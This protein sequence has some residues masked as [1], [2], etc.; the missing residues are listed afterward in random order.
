M[1]MQDEADWLMR[2]HDHVKLQQSAS[3][4]AAQLSVPAGTGLCCYHGEPCIRSEHCLLPLPADKFAVVPDMVKCFERL[5]AL[6]SPTT[7]V[8]AALCPC[9]LG[10]A[11]LPQG[12]QQGLVLQHALESS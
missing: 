1:Q 5:T 8:Q 2:K 9:L 3:S 6:H 7:S 4:A 10:A 12:A 11:S